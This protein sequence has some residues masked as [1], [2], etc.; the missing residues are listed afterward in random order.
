MDFRV[1]VND[2]LIAIFHISDNRHKIELKQSW[3]ILQKAFYTTF[4]KYTTWRNKNLH[5]IVNI[6]QPEEIF[7]INNK[8]STTMIT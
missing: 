2:Y 8:I 3:F 7:Y 1:L 4:C 6:C 5:N